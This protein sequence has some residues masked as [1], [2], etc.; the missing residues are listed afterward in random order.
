MVTTYKLNTRELESAFNSIKT[1]YPDRI[2][3][4]QVREPD[5]AEYL[6][7]DP[8]TRARLEESARNIE[9]GKNLITFESVEQA[10]EAAS[11]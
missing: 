1:T 11:K 10:A 3:E 2:V 9:E 4:I 6:L 7:S 5:A 8:V